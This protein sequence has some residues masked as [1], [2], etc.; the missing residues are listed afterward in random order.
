MWIIKW[1]RHQ[2]DTNRGIV[3]ISLYVDKV[4]SCVYLDPWLTDK[5][6]EKVPVNTRNLWVNIHFYIHNIVDEGLSVSCSMVMWQ[7]V[8]PRRCSPPPWPRQMKIGKFSEEVYC[9]VESL[10]RRS[11]GKLRQSV[12]PNGDFFS[13]N[14]SHRMVILGC[15]LKWAPDSSKWFWWF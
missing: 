1:N 12:A 3:F 11:G 13:N 6:W 15:V 8:Y 7:C 2:Q 5:T 4:V 14:I 10:G 9:M